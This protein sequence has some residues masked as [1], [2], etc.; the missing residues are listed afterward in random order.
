MAA[1]TT[2]LYQSDSQTDAVRV[3]LKLATFPS[4]YQG[5]SVRNLALCSVSDFHNAVCR[6]IGEIFLNE[7]GVKY[8]SN[9]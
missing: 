1:I 8:N 4:V 2:Q 7:F 9:E 6:S 3:Q 5:T